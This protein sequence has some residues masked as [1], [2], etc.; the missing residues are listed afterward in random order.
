M[1]VK[2]FLLVLLVNVF[3]F[4]SLANAGSLSKVFKKVN[5][6]VVV[7][8]TTERGYAGL[9]PGQQATFN[10]GGLGSG[11][12]VSKEGLI[13]TAAHVV[14]VADAVVVKFVDGNMVGAKVV[15]S[16][17]Q[18]DVALLQ[19][20]HLPDNLA[21]AELGD[22]DDVNIGDEIFVIGAPYGV[23]HTLTVGYMSGRRHPEIVCN[24][25]LPIEFLQTDAAINK[26]NSGGP[27]FNMD[28]KV[29]GIVS[30][31]LSYSG[32]SE[33]LGFAVS[34][35]TAKELL[36]NQ[37]SVWTGLEAYLVSGPLAK[38]LNVPQEAGLLVQRVAED[39]PS[40]RLGLRPGNIPVEIGG[41]Q[42]LLGGD[43]VLEVKGVTVSEDI[44]HTCEIRKKVTGL[45]QGNLEM[46]VLRNGKVLDLAI[47]REGETEDSD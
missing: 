17:P 9:E 4:N 15:G 24:S 8:L 32:G 21:V 5:P 13:M 22:S 7:I 10:K 19:L 23:D 38:A 28:G 3:V 27:M 35:N 39:S 36:L 18:A 45:N 29:I 34:I 40:Q 30:R 12:V 11:I 16:A 43:I 42:L 1:R 2:S 44:D 31:I 20:N 47:F 14:Q 37:G 25:L 41:K 26:G 33:G 6:A 46:K